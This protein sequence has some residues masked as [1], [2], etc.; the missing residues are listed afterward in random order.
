MLSTNPVPP[1]LLQYLRD[2][3]KNM[4]GGM[5]KPPG[6]PNTMLDSTVVEKLQDPN[7]SSLAGG[8][9]PGCVAGPGLSQGGRAVAS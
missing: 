6:R 4:S 1:A 3:L 7:K 8:W 2:R 9:V 5:L